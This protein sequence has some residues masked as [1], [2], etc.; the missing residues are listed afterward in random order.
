MGERK[1]LWE[2]RGRSQKANII[3]CL[4]FEVL[5]ITVL[6]SSVGIVTRQ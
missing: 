5:K 6:W 1:V 2:Q 4:T 3:A